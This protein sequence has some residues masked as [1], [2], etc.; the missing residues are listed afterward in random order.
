M[1]TSCNF[2]NVLIRFEI[3]CHGKA[4]NIVSCL[5]DTCI[6]HCLHLQSHL[7][8]DKTLNLPNS[9]PVFIHGGGYDSDG[10][11]IW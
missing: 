4:N 8:K 11:S 10:G 7:D 2:Q 6:M 5:N 1:S 9:H 3:S